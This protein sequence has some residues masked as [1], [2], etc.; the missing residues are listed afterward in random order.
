M[1][2]EAVR[3][4]QRNSARNI[5]EGRLVAIEALLRKPA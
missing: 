1:G 2:E 5:A 3:E 4:A